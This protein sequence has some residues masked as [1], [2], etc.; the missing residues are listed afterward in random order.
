MNLILAIKNL[1]TKKHWTIKSSTD[2]DIP[3]VKSGTLEC[4]GNFFAMII[5]MFMIEVRY[6]KIK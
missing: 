6:P 3:G 5:A 2:A 1:F 4:T